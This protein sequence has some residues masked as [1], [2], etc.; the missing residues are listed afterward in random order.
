MKKLFCLLIAVAMI[1][2]VG[3]IALLAGADYVPSVQYQDAPILVTPSVPAE[4]LPDD[5]NPEDEIKGIIIKGET[6][7]H[8]VYESECEII[9][10]SKAYAAIDDETC[11]AAIVARSSK[12]IEV[13]DAL[14]ASISDNIAGI[15]EFAAALGFS[16][17][18]FM[19]KNIFDLYV[20]R[21]LSADD[22]V[23]H[24]IFENNMDVTGGAF[25]VAHYVDDAWVIVDNDKVIFED[26]NIFVEF[27]EL[28]PIVFIAVE[29]ADE[30]TTTAGV[31]ETT[32]ETTDEVTTPGDDDDEDKK[33]GKSW[34]WIVIISA[35]V[36]VAGGVTVY[37]LWK[38]GIIRFK[39]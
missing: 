27:D 5:Y 28:C 33:T 2:S 13:N 23:I 3:S 39:K 6:E 34:I 17:P 25:I 37:V 8:F 15:D 12:L 9:S 18:K 16:A 38:K 19:I 1:A 11:D 31:D 20:D 35:T 21:D 24:F 10:L 22:D 29:E 36:V 4:E 32:D 26:D 7:K 14:K 30:E